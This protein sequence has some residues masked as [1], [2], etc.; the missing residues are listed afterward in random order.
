MGVFTTF[1]PA[2]AGL[3][4]A[5]AAMALA[6]GPAACLARV[7]QLEQTGFIKGYRA[8]LDAA[9]LGQAMSLF[10]EVKLDRTTQD[11]FT[12]F[13][14]AV[15]VVPE[16]LE[17]HMVAG[18]FDYLI[19]VRVASMDTYREVLTNLL[20]ELPGVRETHT[21]AVIEEVKND[22]SIQVLPARRHHGRVRRRGG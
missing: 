8:I 14:K 17:C 15:A 7:R 13:A 16:I 10:V 12:R 3:L 6:A 11:A 18:G 9:K 20:V 5:A 1:R 22:P 21:Y 4:L 19:K 2:R